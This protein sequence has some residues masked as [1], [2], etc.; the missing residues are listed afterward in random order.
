MTDTLTPEEQPSDVVGGEGH[1]LLTLPDGR[2]IAFKAHPLADLFPMMSADEHAALVEDVRERGVQRP[3]VLLDGM[4]L[5]GRN[6]YMAAR[7]AEV[8]Y[9][10]VEFTGSDPLAFV[11]SENM[12]RRHLTDSQRAMVAAKIARLPKGANQHSR[13]SADLPTLSTAAAAEQLSVPVRTVTA[14]K[15]VVRDG[16]AELVAAVETGQVSVSAAAEVA[17]LPEAEQQEIVAQGPAA[18]KDAAKA[19]RHKADPVA[20]A[21]DVEPVDPERRKLAKLTTDALID[22]VLGLR[23]SLEDAKAKVAA[24]KAEREDL[25]EK[26][27]TATSGE[28][29]RVIGQLQRQLDQLKG[30]IGEHQT[31]AKRWEHRAKKAEA[32]VKVLENMEVVIQ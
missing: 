12:R 19:A 13:A 18:V 29:G 23:A 28:Q 17:K 26:L 8:G 3:I 1:G 25:T 11:I 9:R 20:P 4:V 21:P 5:D 24:L 15:S 6:R 14:A 30:R 2:S 31:A 16:A 27:A 22:D 32:R 10:V 7:D